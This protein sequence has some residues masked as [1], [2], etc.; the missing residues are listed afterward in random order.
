MACLLNLC[1]R[2][3]SADTYAG[4]HKYTFNCTIL[5]R[6]VQEEPSDKGGAAYGWWLRGDLYSVHHPKRRTRLGQPVWPKGVLPTHSPRE[7]P[8]V[9]HSESPFRHGLSFFYQKYWSI[10]G[11]RCRSAM[12]ISKKEFPAYLVYCFAWDIVQMT[13]L[14]FD[15]EKIG[16]LLVDLKGF[17]IWILTHGVPSPKVSTLQLQ[18]P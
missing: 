5:C 14:S 15:L 11:K 6:R 4:V 7:V 12:E 17:C 18:G 8:R 16:K 3:D 13:V 10:K 2:T 1:E 9:T